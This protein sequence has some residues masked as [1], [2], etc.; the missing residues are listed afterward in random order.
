MPLTNKQRS[1]I[2]RVAKAGGFRGD[3]TDLFNQAEKD[4]IFEDGGFDPNSTTD[5]YQ[6]SNNYQK[7][8]GSRKGVRA[9]YD[10]KGRRVGESSNDESR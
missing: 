2:I 4:G 10:D 9:N 6:E 3:Y 5:N 1:S 7:I 8:K